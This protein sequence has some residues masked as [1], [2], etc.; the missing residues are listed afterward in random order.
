MYLCVYKK[1]QKI[2]P[3]KKRKEGFLFYF[4]TYVVLFHETY[5]SQEISLVMHSSLLRLRSLLLYY[6][7]YYFFLNSIV[8]LLLSIICN[9]CVLNGFNK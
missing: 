4:L 1:K 7:Y 3:K 9:I 6:Y 8:L 2:Y 5:N